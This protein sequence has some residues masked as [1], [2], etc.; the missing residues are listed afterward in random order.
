MSRFVLVI[1]LHYYIN[2]TDLIDEVLE[3]GGLLDALDSAGVDP[4]SEFDSWVSDCHIIHYH[5]RSPLSSQFSHHVCFDFISIKSA[6]RLHRSRLEVD[7]SQMQRRACNYLQ[8][9]SRAPPSLSTIMYSHPYEMPV[10]LF[11]KLKAYHDVQSAVRRLS[12]GGIHFDS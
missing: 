9:L 4:P 8:V 5:S 10:A 11:S 3:V 6:Y 7:S 1:F 12:D 2:D